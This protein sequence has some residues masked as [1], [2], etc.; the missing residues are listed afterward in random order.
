M[1]TALKGILDG[2]GGFQGV[3]SKLGVG[4]DN[5]EPTLAAGLVNS[6]GPTTES[7]FMNNLSNDPFANIP[8]PE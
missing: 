4:G 2:L 8:L 7:Q 1:G 6:M 5:D 3:I